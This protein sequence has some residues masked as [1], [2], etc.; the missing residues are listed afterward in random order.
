MLY[1]KR[2][3]LDLGVFAALFCILSNMALVLRPTWSNDSKFVVP[4]VIIIT[5]VLL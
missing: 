2:S 4:I 1:F 5:L 3:Y